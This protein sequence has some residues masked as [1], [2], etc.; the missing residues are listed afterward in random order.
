M[1]LFKFLSRPRSETEEM[2]LSTSRK[3]IITSAAIY[4]GVHFIA[5][6]FWTDIFSPRL[7]L[8]T[9]IMLATLILSLRILPRNQ[10]LGKGLWFTGLSAAVLTA[11]HLFP[12]PE[13]LLLFAVFPMMAEVMLGVRGTLIIA[14]ILLV[15][16]FFLPHIPFQQ[17]VDNQYRLVLLIATLAGGIFGWALSDNLIS[18]NETANYHYYEALKRLEE[19]RR[20]RAEISVLLKEQSK[21]NYQLDRLN[22][23]LTI[24]RARA[25]EARIDRDRFALAVSHELRSPLNFIIGFSDLMVNSPETYAPLKRW[26]PG[27]YDDIKEV[28]RSSNHLLALIN[29]IL[30]MGKIDAQQIT[31]FKERLR[32]SDLIEEVR[33][34]VEPAV[35]NKKWPAPSSLPC[36]PCWS[37][38]SWAATSCAA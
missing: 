24:A 19:T 28:Y 15:F 22:K 27:L 34:I 25:E 20:H 33:D 11:Y 5:T 29:D 16:I 13:I 4:L 6:L 12:A 36:R 18:A 2:L 8:V 37:T 1:K 3:I 23:M 32:V 35:I 10:T 30:E 7:W 9:L 26:P 17:P 14:G 21:S 38:S 31:L